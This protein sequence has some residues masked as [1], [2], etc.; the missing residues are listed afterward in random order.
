MGPPRVAL[1]VVPLQDRSEL[2][3][4]T[5]LSLLLLVRL[6]PTGPEHRLEWSDLYKEYERLIDNAFSDFAAQENLEVCPLPASTSG[7][8]H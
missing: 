6:L 3:L 1:V 2:V 7:C 4:S 8:G 5:Y